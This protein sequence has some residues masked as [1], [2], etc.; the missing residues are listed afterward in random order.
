MKTAELEGA[1]LDYYVAK[2]D[3][4]PIYAAGTDSW[5]GNAHVHRESFEHSVVLISL[6]G[7]SHG[8]FIEHSG[9]SMRYSPSVNWEYA[10]PIIEHEQ[11]PISPVVG[12]TW[13]SE[14]VC[15]QGEDDADTKTVRGKTPLIAA[16]RAFV[17][18]KFGDEVEDIPSC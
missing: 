6:M 13:E 8:L 11:I 7:M 12:G 10:G 14:Y 17:A 4:L 3:G 9:K 18:S 16:M 5:P 1:V 15:W 2:A